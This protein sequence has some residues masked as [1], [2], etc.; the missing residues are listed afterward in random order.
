MKIKEIIK[1]SSLASALLLKCFG[2][3][4]LPTFDIYRGLQDAQT[5]QTNYLFHL[6]GE[7]N[8][9]SMTEDE[10]LY[11]TKQ[12]KR[13]FGQYPTVGIDIVLEEITFDTEEKLNSF[14]GALLGIRNVCSLHGSVY[15]GIGADKK[16]YPVGFVRPSH[17][18]PKS[19]KK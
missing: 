1:L 7:Q 8:S 2:D 3:V 6:C 11:M 17:Q 13:M 14:F 5:N 9:P 18:E 10:M 16:L 19:S 4:E 12:L 15:I